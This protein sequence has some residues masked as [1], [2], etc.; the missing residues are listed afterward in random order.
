MQKN[1]KTSKSVI[2]LEKETEIR[3]TNNF[4]TNWKSGLSPKEARIKVKE[5]LQ[6]SWKGKYG[7]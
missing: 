1:T 2:S 6:K 7:G 3:L 5:H 4:D